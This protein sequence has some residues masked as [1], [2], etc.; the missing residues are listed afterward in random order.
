LKLTFQ[1]LHG[2][3]DAGANGLIRTAK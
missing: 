1:V 3:H 2:T